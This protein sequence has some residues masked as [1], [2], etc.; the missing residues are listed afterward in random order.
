VGVR[1]RPLDQVLRQAR[2]D[3]AGRHPLAPFGD[4]LGFLA[5]LDDLRP[6]HHAHTARTAVVDYGHGEFTIAQAVDV[7]LTEG[8]AGRHLDAVGEA[9]A[10]VAAV[11]LD[12][13]TQLTIARAVDAQGL[14]GCQP[15]AQAE[16]HSRA[17]VA[18]HEQ[19]STVQLALGIH[20]FLRMCLGAGRQTAC[21]TAAL[22]AD[23]QRGYSTNRPTLVPDQLLRRLLQASACDNEEGR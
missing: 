2:I 11:D 10:A 13:G 16:R 20:R 17:P 23:T 4:E 3:L 22:D 7:T 9:G 19:G 5:A 1:E 8:A 6:G 12:Q 14:Q 15:G 18:M 21:H